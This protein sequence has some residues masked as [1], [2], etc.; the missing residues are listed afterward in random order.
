[1]TLRLVEQTASE[2]E[3]LGQGST[4]LALMVCH[5]CALGEASRP[6]G[7]SLTWLVVIPR[8]SCILLRQPSGT[9]CFVSTPG[10]WV[11]EVTSAGICG[12]MHG[13][14]TLVAPSWAQPP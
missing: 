2:V 8:P 4:V 12:A 10:A 7:Y 9:L 14:G 5:L 6:S 3:Q 13:P 11:A 1:M